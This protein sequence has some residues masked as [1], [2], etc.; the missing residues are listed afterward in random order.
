MD[1]PPKGILDHRK[2]PSDGTLQAFPRE[3]IAQA[4]Q[5]VAV[6]PESACFRRRRRAMLASLR[7]GIGNATGW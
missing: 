2:L 6:I 4:I 3:S 7:T 5:E 1:L